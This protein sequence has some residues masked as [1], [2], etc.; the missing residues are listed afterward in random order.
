MFIVIS[1]PVADWDGGESVGGE[2][3][4]AAK[5]CLCARFDKANGNKRF[6]YLV[7][8]SLE[9]GWGVSVNAIQVIVCCGLQLLDA[10]AAF[11]SFKAQL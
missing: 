1:H 10:A 8:I 9:G 7:V 2:Y 5:K 11:L 4:A 6:F 3:I